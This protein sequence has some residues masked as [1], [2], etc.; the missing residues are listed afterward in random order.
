MRPS[1]HGLDRL[2]VTFDDEH[3]VGGAGLLLPST[4]AAHVD[5]RELFDGDPSNAQPAWVQRLASARRMA[6]RI[7]L[8]MACVLGISV[9]G[10]IGVSVL[11]ACRSSERLGRYCHVQLSSFGRLRSSGFALLA[12]FESPQ[13]RVVLPELSD[14]TL[15]KLL[16]CFD[17]LCPTRRPPVGG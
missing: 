5:L 4:L 8:I 6:V 3:A 11:G 2:A 15:A 16:G 10:A 14:L 17:P 13:F 1:C 9:E 12:T 7:D